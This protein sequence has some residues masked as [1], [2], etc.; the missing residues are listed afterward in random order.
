MSFPVHANVGAGKTHVI[1]FWEVADK[2]A[3]LALS[4]SV[5]QIGC[6]ARQLDDNSFWVCIGASPTLWSPFYSYQTIGG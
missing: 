1:Q 6:V 4:P 2:A 5:A 3:R